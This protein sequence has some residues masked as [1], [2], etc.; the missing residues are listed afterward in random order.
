MG[1]L[2]MT[3]NYQFGIEEEYFLVDAATKAIVVTR[4]E[5]FLPSLKKELACVSRVNKSRLSLFPPCSLDL[6]QQNRADIAVGFSLEFVC[7][8]LQVVEE[9]KTLP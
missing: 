8:S 5:I 1:V 2:T 3:E 9:I 7:S 6:N 4:P